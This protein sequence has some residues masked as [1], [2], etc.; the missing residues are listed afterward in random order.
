MVLQWSPLQYPPAMALAQHL[1]GD[2]QRV[3]SGGLLWGGHGLAAGLQLADGNPADALEG[4]VGLHLLQGDD[5]DVTLF[6]F[7][8]FKEDL[9]KVLD[10]EQP[11]HDG[12]RTATESRVSGDILEAQCSVGLGSWDVTGSCLLETSLPRKAPTESPQPIHMSLPRSLTPHRPTT[13]VLP[14]RTRQGHPV[15]LLTEPWAGLAEP[16]V[17]L[18]AALP[19]AAPKAAWPTEP[20][21]QVLTPPPGPPSPAFVRWQAAS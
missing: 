16:G 13:R 15:L 11:L 7:D 2:Q 5:E 21:H 3:Q 6:V 1:D 17:F 19:L 18:G 14:E 8:G 10:P 9:P 20:P 4:L 12:M